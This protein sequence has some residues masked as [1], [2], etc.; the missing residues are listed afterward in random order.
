MI[1][2]KRQRFLNDG[3][4][5]TSPLSLNFTSIDNRRSSLSL[6]QA[7]WQSKLTTLTCLTLQN[8]QIYDFFREWKLKLPSNFL[9]ASIKYCW[10]QK[11]HQQISINSKCKW[12]KPRM[13]VQ[14]FSV[15]L[16]LVVGFTVG[17]RLIERQSKF[18]D[19]VVS[20]M[21]IFKSFIVRQSLIRFS[22]SGSFNRNCWLWSWSSRNWN[23]RRIQT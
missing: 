4:S 5:M 3:I 22:S 9:M 2:Y 21:N 13:D 18:Q 16:M 15:F 11:F 20:V 1:F 23:S 10:P 17:K 7:V 19:D 14:V 8:D 12:P 6:Y